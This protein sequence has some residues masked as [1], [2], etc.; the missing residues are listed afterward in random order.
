MLE[1]S[2]TTSIGLFLSRFPLVQAKAHNPERN[3][4]KKGKYVDL[5]CTVYELKAAF[6]PSKAHISPAMC[7][8]QKDY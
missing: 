5:E 7:H 4:G 6:L 2:L 8:G 1:T 3:W